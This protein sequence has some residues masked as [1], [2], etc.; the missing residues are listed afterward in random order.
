MAEDSS[1]RVA[2]IATAA[3]EQSAA[4]EEINRSIA[5]VNA[6]SADIAVAMEESANEVAQMATQARVL[7]E[8]LDSIRQDGTSDEA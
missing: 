4:S 3:T 5:E 1:S 6:L 8:I 7:K 2:A